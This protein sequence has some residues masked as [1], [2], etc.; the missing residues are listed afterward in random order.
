MNTLLRSATEFLLADAPEVRARCAALAGRTVVVELT[1]FD[2]EF[3]I[4]PR[5]GGLDVTQEGADDADARVRGRSFDLLRMARGGRAGSDGGV[6][7][8]GDAEL[9][10]DLRNL[11]RDAGWD[12]EERLARLVGDMPAHELGRLARGVHAAAGDAGWRLAGMAAE[13][14]KFETRDLARPDEVEEFVLAV[15]RLRDDVERA[16]A[17]LQGIADNVG[18]DP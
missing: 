15:D 7:V 12:P 9:V 3:C 14:L 17:R 18:A 2:L 1:D 16:A 10:Q 8:A 6:Q 11:M 4:R 5:A 13:F